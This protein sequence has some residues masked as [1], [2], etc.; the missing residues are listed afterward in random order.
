MK[1][2]VKKVL[3]MAF[4]TPEP[5]RKTEFLKNIEQPRISTFSIL[6]TQ[7][8]YIRKRVWFISAV[9]MACAIMSIR[10]VGQD[11]IWAVSAMMPFIALCVV[12]ENARSK[13]Y[14]MSELEMASRFSFR[15]I[16]LAR[17]GAI[18]FVHLLIFSVLVFVVDSK[19]L[20]S[21]LQVG[22][23]LLTPYLLTAVLG[24]MAVR[25]MHGKDVLYG[26]VSIAVMVSFLSMILRANIPQMYAEKYF[27]WWC[28]FAVYLMVK[29]GN[30]CK[31]MIFQTEE[32]AWN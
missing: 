32:M 12:T 4:E 8:S 28:V 22:I 3:E 21:F 27:I 29:V 9:I 2:D 15:S 23:Y 31:M 16:T 7:I 13:T 14:G 26:C 10:Y 5:K 17:L 19:V 25:K 20:L 6:L 1:S 24:L 11:C 30:E 18:G